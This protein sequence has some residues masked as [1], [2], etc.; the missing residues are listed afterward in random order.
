M[1]TRRWIYA[2]PAIGFLVAGLALAGSQLWIGFRV[3]G[4]ISAGW[5]GLWLFIALLVALNPSI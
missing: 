4:W 3:V 2:L 5:A 1:R